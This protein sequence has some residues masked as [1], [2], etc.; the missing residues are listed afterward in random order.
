MKNIKNMYYET[1]NKLQ[2]ARDCYYSI[3]QSLD[4]NNEELKNLYNKI[5]NWNNRTEKQNK[6]LEEKHDEEKGL[7]KQQKQIETIQSLLLNNLLHIQRELLN[8]SAEVLKNSKYYLKPFGEKTKEKMQNEIKEYLKNKYD[9]ELYVYIN[10]SQ[11]YTRDKFHNYE[12]CYEIEVIYQDYYYEYGLKQEKIRVFQ[13]NVYFYY[14]DDIEYTKLQELENKA[15]KIIEKN[16]KAEEKIE[17][18]RKEIEKL[19]YS[20]N[21]DIKGFLHNE[22]YIS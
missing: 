8:E 1:T 3:K 15:N 7:L 22:F 16:Q 10:Q 20:N 11:E 21:K 19:K 14:Y 13:N 6:E 4:L 2:D 9:I 5:D 17:T 18:L 12:W